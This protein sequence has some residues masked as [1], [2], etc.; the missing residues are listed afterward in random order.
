MSMGKK[1]I[2]YLILGVLI[3]FII[4]S[5]ITYNVYNSGE[6]DK[7]TEQR[8]CSIN[9]ATCTNDNK[10]RQDC[11]EGWVCGVGLNAGICIESQSSA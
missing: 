8:D 9:E 7:I 1:I 5:L 6:D 4:G 10:C 2:A 11:G 3:G